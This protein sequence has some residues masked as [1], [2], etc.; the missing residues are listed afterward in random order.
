MDNTD[1]KNVRM[2]AAPNECTAGKQIAR[3]VHYEENA[4]LGARGG[5][6]CVLLKLVDAH[7][8]M[9]K[10]ILQARPNRMPHFK[11]QNK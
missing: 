7:Q 3:E 1:R 9:R 6:P 2:D 8:H 11:Q 10:N 4:H 5:F